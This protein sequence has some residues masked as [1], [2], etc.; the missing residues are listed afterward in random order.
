MLF[1]S[2]YRTL[3]NWITSSTLRLIYMT[4]KMQRF[5]VRLASCI[6]RIKLFSDQMA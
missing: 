1:L 4:T 5:C 2:L 6:N 3:W